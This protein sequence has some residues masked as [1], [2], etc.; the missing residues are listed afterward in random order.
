VD[1]VSGALAPKESHRRLHSEIRRAQR[2]HRELS[3]IVVSVR[4]DHGGTPANA[5]LKDLIQTLERGLRA[6]VDWIGRLDQTRCAEF[7]VVLPEAAAADLPAIRDRVLAALAQ[8]RVPDGSGI[9]LENG[10]AS[11]GALIASGA[12]LDVGSM[13]RAAQAMCR[14]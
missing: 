10:I 5:I 2:Y 13:L 11:M 3:V 9:S 14:E 8:Y 1:D 12:Q 6:D 4:D 7:V